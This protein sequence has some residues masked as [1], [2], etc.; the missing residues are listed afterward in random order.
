MDDPQSV[1]PQRGPQYNASSARGTE[2]DPEYQYG[3]DDHGAQA[4][5]PR[6]GVPPVTPGT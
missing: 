1:P 3:N 2:A 6:D 5:T 4:E